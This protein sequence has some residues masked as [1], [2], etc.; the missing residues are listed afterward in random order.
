MI[1]SKISELADMSI[2]NIIEV[3]IPVE[4]QSKIDAG[5][6]SIKGTQ[7]RDKKGRIVKNLESLA[8]DDSHYF[9]PQIFIRFDQS[10]IVSNT[11]ISVNLQN[12]LDEERT[13][14]T[15]LDGKIDTLLERQGNELIAIV[16]EFNEN[17]TC[18][19]EGNKLVDE[20]T[21]YSTG[22]KAA[23]L[24]ASNIESY[25]EEYIHSTHVEYEGSIY[26]SDYGAYNL[27]YHENKWPPSITENKFKRFRECHGSYLTYSF[28]NIIN[29]INILSITYN[30]KPFARYSTN[31]IVLEKQ[32][33]SVLE[34]LI[35]GLGKE[36]DIFDMM[37]STDNGDYYFKI[38]LERLLRQL[39]KIDIH[40][41]ILRNYSKQINIKR[42]H[43]RLS[44]IMDIVSI[45]EEIENLKSRNESLEALDLDTPEDLATVKK[46]IFANN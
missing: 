16:S 12:R 28:I 43:D 4:M 14:L 25:L 9:S 42:D 40:D 44:S 30:G 6:Y 13:K 8:V 38:E 20:K 27:K 24:L 17:F 45:L 23:S 19:L 41:L 36:R 32:L 5:D 15:L 22:V 29:S 33:R 46:L 11:T 10:V 31:L 26:G 18:L 34:R 1:T 39:P 37:F 35:E 2:E 3:K 7:I 21:T